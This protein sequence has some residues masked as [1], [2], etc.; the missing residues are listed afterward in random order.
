VQQ[1]QK[2]KCEYGNQPTAAGSQG[3]A[4][5]ARKENRKGAEACKVWQRTNVRTV[6]LHA[7]H[8]Q[9]HAPQQLDADEELDP[10][11]AFTGVGN[12]LI[13]LVG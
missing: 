8:E 5:D 10:S 3:L 4:E 6:G 2:E 9:Q 1:I 11:P 12:R 13:R 7:R